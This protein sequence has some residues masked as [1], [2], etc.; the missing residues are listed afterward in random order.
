M[1]HNRMKKQITK[2]LLGMMAVG[3]LTACVNDSYDM[4]KDIDMTMQLGTEGLQIKL[5]NTERINLKDILEIDDEEAIEED[6]NGLFYLVKEGETDVSYNVRRVNTEV[7]VATLSPKIKMV[8]IPQSTPSFTVPAGKVYKGQGMASEKKP[9]HLDFY[10]VDKEVVSL[11][12]IEPAGSTINFRVYLDVVS[13]NPN[14]K[15]II[16]DIKDLVVELPY[17]IKSNDAKGGK[18][19]LKDGTYNSGHIEFGPYKLDAFEADGEL[20]IKPERQPN[21]K[22]KIDLFDDIQFSG[23]ASLKAA[24]S[25]TMKGGDQVNLQMT[26]KFDGQPGNV[27]PNTILVEF[28]EVTGCYDPDID[29]KINP[30]DVASDLPDFLDDDEV[31][32]NVNNPTVR[33]DVDMTKIPSDLEFSGNIS[34]WKDNTKTA[35]VRIPESKGFAYIQRNCPNTL[36]FYQGNEPYD[37]AGE[38]AVG[39]LYQISNLNQLVEKIPDEIRVDLG[40]NAV[41]IKPN[42]LSTIEFGR[43]YSTAAKY[44]VWVPF[45]FDK[46]LKVVYSDST[47]S[48]KDDLED[49]SAEGAELTANVTSTVPLEMLASIIPLDKQGKEITTIHVSKANISAGKDDGVGSTEKIAMDVVFTKP[50]DLKK[51]D[52]MKFRIEAKSNEAGGKLTSKQFVEVNDM[53]IKLKGAVIADFN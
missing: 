12:R 30:I 42:T 3:S 10:D 13:N 22:N 48:F 19:K 2:G 20:G 31:T 40:K 5:G 33:F 45:Q 18:L 44:F 32:I 21:N 34:S 29:P 17:F 52:R 38:T 53:R 27:K 41:H 43:T 24:S 6:K 51:L 35:S 25:F 14:H 47:K 15:F 49:Y 50:D 26:V 37:P 4:S 8:D 39:D 9:F 1:E 36:Y 7:D 11:K 46:G 16:G 23:S 28:G